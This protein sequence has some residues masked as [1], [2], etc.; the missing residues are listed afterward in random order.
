[1]GVLMYTT[2]R[3][4]DS[5]TEIIHKLQD[6]Q[7]EYGWLVNNQTSSEEIKNATKIWDTLQMNDQCCGINAPSDWVAY[8][9]VESDTMYPISCCMNFT[10]TSARVGNNCTIKSTS[11]WSS[12][13]LDIIKGV[14]SNI[15][16]LLTALVWLNLLLSLMAC[17]VLLCHPKT[18]YIYYN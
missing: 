1:M 13:C 16:V 5:T 9:P 11:M 4:N 10:E 15:I 18:D 3:L 2:P 8:M 14:N 6:L 17:F 12:G 7:P